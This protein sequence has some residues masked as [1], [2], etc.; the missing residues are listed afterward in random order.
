MLSLAAQRLCAV[1]FLIL[2]MC[3]CVCQ[4][5]ATLGVDAAVLPSRAAPAN[6]SAVAV[7]LHSTATDAFVTPSGAPLDLRGVNIVPLGAEEPSRTLSGSHYTEIEREGFNAVRLVVYWDLLEPHRGRFDHV[8]LHTLDR[9]IARAQASR[10]YVIL[11]EIHLWGRRGMDGIPRWARRGDSVTSV[12]SNG[13][14]YLRML[15]RR[16][17]EEPAV[18]GYDLVNEFHRYPIDQNSVLG[19][20]NTLIRQVRA[21]DRNKIILIEPTYGDTSVAGALANFRILTERRNV[22]WSIHD[23][24][25]GGNADGYGADGG[26]AGNYTWDGRT[27]YAHPDPTELENHLLVQLRKMRAVRLP[28]WIGVFGIGAAAVNHDRWIADQVALFNKYGLGRMWWEYHTS[29]PFSAT[30]DDYAW[31]RWTGLLLSNARRRGFPD[32]TPTAATGCQTVG[33]ARATG[34]TRSVVTD[35]HPLCFAW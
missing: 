8:A 6:G 15:A 19:A 27:G 3:S 11:D 4:E 17:R 35:R 22:V 25:A 9:A 21:V 13:G 32:M 23:Y 7:P 18:A 1:S 30:S 26:Q 33:R 2:G 29:S 14:A 28:I 10:L 12:L 20:Y 31:K 16:Y 5:R 34:G 24:F